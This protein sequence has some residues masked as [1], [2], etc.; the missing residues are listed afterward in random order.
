MYLSG[1]EDIL[2]KSVISTVISAMDAA[3]G[4]FEQRDVMRYLRSVLSPVDPDTC[5][6]VENYAITWGIRGSR[7]LTSWEN[8]PDGL[9]AQ[10][11]DE[12]RALLN[13]LNQTRELAVLPL[14]K[15]RQGFQNAKN[16]KE[17]V[18]ALYGLL[19]D[20]ELEQRLDSLAQ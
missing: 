11:D 8:H 14:E 18:L 5:D 6:L 13:R 1:T 20:I 4:G 17:Q 16:L 15:L 12:S 19:E 7:W 3:L 9:S 2:Q 10:W